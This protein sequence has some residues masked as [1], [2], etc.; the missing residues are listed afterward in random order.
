MNHRR[1]REAVQ[2]YECNA[3]GREIETNILRG[4]FLEF[5]IA[6]VIKK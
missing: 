4:V 6:Q 2:P 1:H 3:P 5:H